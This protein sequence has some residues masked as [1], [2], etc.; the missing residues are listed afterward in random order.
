M[1]KLRM[2]PQRRVILDVLRNRRWHPTADELF[3]A[4]RQRLP[5]VSLGTVYRN[6]DQLSQAGLVR[7]LEFSDGARRFDGLVVKHT[8]A[9]CLR[10]GG[11]EDFGAGPGPSFREM[12]EV[13]G[14]GRRRADRVSPAA[15]ALNK[16]RR[17]DPER[18]V[19]TE[20]G[21]R[22]TGHRLEFVGICSRCALSDDEHSSLSLHREVGRESG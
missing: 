4:V 1:A 9:R 7:G 11:I 22:V 16:T 17:G 19:T 15:E 10:C 18:G 20:S 2:S 21:F 13:L 5:H 6:L 12:L 3:Q 14:E 8:H